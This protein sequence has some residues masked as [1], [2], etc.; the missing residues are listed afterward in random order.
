MHKL[1]TLYILLAVLAGF[2]TYAQQSG[3]T[4]TLD[5]DTIK[6]GAQANLTLKTIVS[7]NTKVNFPTGKTFGM[8]EVLEAYPTDTVKKGAL[9][10][11]SKKYGITQFDAGKY[12]IP[13]LTVVIGKKLVD[14][15]QL[16]LEV[17]DVAVDTLKQKMYDIKPV[18]AGPA[19]S[20]WWLYVLIT[21]AVAALGYFGWKWYKKRKPRAKKGEEVIVLSPIE[22]AT[23]H[24]QQLEQKALL[25]KG[26]VKEYYSELTDIA[27]TYIEEAIE[28]PAMESTTGELIEAMHKAAQRKKMRLQEE[29]FSQLERVLRTADMVKFAK[30]VPPES[31]IAEDRQ[32]IVKSIVVIEE[33]IPVDVIDEEDKM[34]IALR[35]KQRRDAKRR[36][37]YTGI[38]IA[39]FVLLLGG[40]FFGGRYI[41]D[42]YIGNTTQELLEGEWVKSEYGMPGVSIETPKVMVRYDVSKNVPEQAKAITKEMATFQYGSIGGKFYVGVTTALYKQPLQSDLS[43]AFEATAATW[44]KMGVKN[45]SVKQDP[46]T[47]EDGSM[48]LRCFGTMRVPDE[49]GTGSE[50]AYYEIIYYAQPQAVQ[51]VTILHREGDAAAA[52]I[53]KRTKNSVE[54]KKLK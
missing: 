24:L 27:R 42:N 30:A 10:E 43:K 1:R 38:G 16:T 23:T 26:A 8:L 28:I 36:K 41:R 4:A 2:T 9:L 13:P 7:T 50:R 54:F 35:E 31:T 12:T 47:T 15:K 14:T 29:I 17:K 19:P 40:V 25:Q 52:E 34:A 3:V 20:L 44:E 46:F 21:L 32:T 22:K 11:L 51:Q 45:I 48:G 37:I 33:A 49:L 53:L 6:I 5:K 39:A 18:I